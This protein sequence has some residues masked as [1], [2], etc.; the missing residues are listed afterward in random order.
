MG[1]IYIQKFLIYY[2]P[3]QLFICSDVMVDV[4]GGI[5]RGYIMVVVYWE[6]LSDTEISLHFKYLILH[7]DTGERIAPVQL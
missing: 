1:I 5:E 4:G 2:T 6:T 7:H 3:A